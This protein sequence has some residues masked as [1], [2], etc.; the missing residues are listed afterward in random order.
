VD[1]VTLSGIS[2]LKS[3]VAITIQHASNVNEIENPTEEN[4]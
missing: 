1:T 3:G 4:K 2:R